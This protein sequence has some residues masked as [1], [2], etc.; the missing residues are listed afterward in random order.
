[1]M[2]FFDHHLLGA[3]PY[4]DAPVE[5]QSAPDG[6]YRAE[7]SWPPADSSSRLS[8][9]KAGTYTDDGENRG[10]GADGAAGN[11][12]WSFSQPLAHKAHLSGE[13]VL[14][15][16]LAGAPRANFVVNVY[17]V[18]PDNKALLVSRGAWL[19]RSGSEDASFKLYGQDWV[20]EPGHRVGVL[21]SSANAEWWTHV[22]TG[23]DV[24]VDQAT[25]S[26]PWL[27]YERTEF[28]PG[29]KT[30]RL[31]SHLETAFDVDPAVIAE[32]ETQFDLPPRLA[33]MPARQGGSSQARPSKL[34]ARAK[35]R[36]RTLTVSGKAPASS[37]VTV[38]VTRGARRVAR[39][40]VSARDG[41]Y[42]VR[43]K[44]RKR[45]RYAITVTSGTQKARAKARA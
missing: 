1:M 36:K 13:P 31:E 27:A 16:K 9:L 14:A 40:T 34:T 26:L 20:F 30:G 35:V 3:A 12:I 33:P 41:R 2:R 21:L 42:T 44:L 45:G 29:Q 4:A 39:R 19:M 15:A 5:V 8:G 17:D 25:I 7:A 38:T 11:G 6:R 32:N 23:A 37:A 28:L 22:P 43:V 18:S 24:T 10:Y